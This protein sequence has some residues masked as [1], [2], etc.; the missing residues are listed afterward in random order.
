MRYYAG[1]VPGAGGEIAPD[2][3]AGERDY[4]RVVY[5]PDGAPRKLERYSDGRLRRVD[6]PGAPDEART[7]EAHLREHP[8]VPFATRH[9]RGGLGGF[10]WEE[11]RAFSG[12]GER[13]ETVLF[14]L[15]ADGREW[16]EV[17]HRPGGA[18]AEVVKY[19]WEG[20]ELRYVFHYYRADG[21]PTGIED[22]PHADHATFA[23]IA[24]ALPEA[25]FFATALALPRALAGTGIPAPGEG[26]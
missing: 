16:A 13:T 21:P 2:D 25:D 7:R 18:V 10:R 19:F 23:E 12:S 17:H 14:L 24:G 22:L 8:G 4:V 15:D 3:A 5:G 1:P 9:D 26:Q 11:A 6:Y 20:D